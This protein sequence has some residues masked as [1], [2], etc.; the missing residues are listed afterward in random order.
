MSNLLRHK[1]VHTGFKPFVC[2][3]CEKTFSSSSNLKQHVSIHKS[4][5]KRVKYICFI[6]D[7]CK[8]YY[9]ICTLKKHLI[10]C[11]IDK[12]KIIEEI[13]KDI[14]FYHI[15]K[16][17]K[18]NQHILHSSLSFIK[19]KE[20]LKNEHDFEISEEENSQISY[21][22]N[23]NE[24]YV[25]DST[26][27]PIYQPD[28]SNFM[29]VKN[30]QNFIKNNANAHSNS[31]E[32]SFTKSMNVPE[33][34]KSSLNVKNQLRNF[35]NCPNCNIE[36]NPNRNHSRLPDL[37]NFLG[38]MIKIWFENVSIILRLSDACLNK[39]DKVK[40]I[41]DGFDKANN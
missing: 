4:S 5:I 31:N 25:E 7:C 30:M 17:L 36:E 19:F 32:K 37:I 20:N 38:D 21:N 40:E 11:H 10:Q 13:Y 16:N 33:I 1:R 12:F 28:S 2:H 41:M 15:I 9:Y 6:D 26:F 39:V 24:K 14:N 8:S 18:K 23:I 35:S 22:N 27:N 29:F 3:V 34:S